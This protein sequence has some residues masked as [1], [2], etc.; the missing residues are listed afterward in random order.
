[1]H[2]IDIL[3]VLLGDF[4]IEIL[5]QIGEQWVLLCH[6]HRRLIIVRDIQHDRFLMIIYLT[7]ILIIFGT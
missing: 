5:T 3:L 2:I 6:L 1:M 4:T 7:L